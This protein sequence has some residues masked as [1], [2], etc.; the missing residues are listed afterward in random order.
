MCT[1]S[2]LGNGYIYSTGKIE[3]YLYYLKTNLEM[4][5]RILFDAIICRIR[6]IKTSHF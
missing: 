1:K 4:L 3:I 2:R 5:Q 6:K